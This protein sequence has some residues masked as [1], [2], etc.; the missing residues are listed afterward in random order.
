MHDD[1]LQLDGFE[2]SR[3]RRDALRQQVVDAAPRWYRPWLHLALPA[4]FGLG[5]VAGSILLISELHP[6]E[7]LTIPAVFLAANATEWRAHRDLLHQ[8]MPLAGPLYEQHTLRHHRIFVAH[9]MA[10]RSRDEWRMVLLPAYGILAIFVAT[11]PITVALWLLGMPNVAALFV[12][13]CMAY[14]LSYEWLHLSYHLPEGHWLG[15]T[16][17]IGVLRRH[18]ATHHDPK[19]MQR[20]NFNVTVPLWDWVRGT[21]APTAAAETRQACGPQAKASQRRA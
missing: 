12:A 5:I 19:L 1:T 8:R 16:Q 3:P 2:P 17:L 4:L 7:L 21:V 14:V 18:H 20:Y 6:I 10:M 13:S 9:D 15:G 11:G